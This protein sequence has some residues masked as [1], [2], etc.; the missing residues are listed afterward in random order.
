MPISLQEQA[1]LEGELYGK[2]T[3]TDCSSEMTFRQSTLM[4]TTG[5]FCQ[6]FRTIQPLA[7]CV[8]P[9]EWEA[10]CR[11][12]VARKSSRIPL[13]RPLGTTHQPQG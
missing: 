3:I 4:E 6:W 2:E 12:E 10:G 11:K 9:E 7:L 13:D 5:S 1:D 8:Y